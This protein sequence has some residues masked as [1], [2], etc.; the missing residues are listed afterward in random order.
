MTYSPR[1]TEFTLAPAPAAPRRGLLR[2]IFEA[3]IDSRRRSA[4][5]R[6]RSSELIADA[7][8]LAEEA[9]RQLQ[10]GLEPPAD[11]LTTG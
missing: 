10:L 6:E 3:V 11:P 1:I 5:L 2:R 8:R 7:R 4:E 9:A